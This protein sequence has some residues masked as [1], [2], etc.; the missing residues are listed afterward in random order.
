MR[1][2][3]PAWRPMASNHD[4]PA[5]GPACVNNHTLHPWWVLLGFFVNWG[6]SLEG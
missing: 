6:H 3:G 4:R 2:I 5:T 1:G